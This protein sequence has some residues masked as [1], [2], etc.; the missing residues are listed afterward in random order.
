[1]KASKVFS[2]SSLS[3][4]LTASRSPQSHTT[5]MLAVTRQSRDGPQAE[6][7]EAAEGKLW[8]YLL[9]NRTLWLAQPSSA[10]AWCNVMMAETRFSNSNIAP[11]SQTCNQS[12]L[13]LQLFPISEGNRHNRGNPPKDQPP[14]QRKSS[15]F[16]STPTAAFPGGICLDLS[17]SPAVFWSVQSVWWCVCRSRPRRRAWLI[18]KGKFRS[19]LV[20]QQA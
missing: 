8:F 20:L 10:V 7:G 16:L 6:E 11:S 15:S 14:T 3:S 17:C 5:Y 19:A 2:A 4:Q 12:H 1:M 18:Q 9:S 13:F